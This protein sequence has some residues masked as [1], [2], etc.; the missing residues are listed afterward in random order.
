MMQKS[1]AVSICELEQAQ[2]KV[3]LQAGFS[4]EHGNYDTYGIMVTQKSREGW[5]VKDEISDVT[6]DFRLAYNMAYKFNLGRLTMTHFRDV[7]EDWLSM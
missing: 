7:V 1:A 3:I 6:T 2:Y 5:Y 4:E